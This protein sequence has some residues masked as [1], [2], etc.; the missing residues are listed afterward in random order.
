MNVGLTL[1]IAA[2]SAGEKFEKSLEF[3]RQVSFV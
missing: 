2:C 1:V 3:D